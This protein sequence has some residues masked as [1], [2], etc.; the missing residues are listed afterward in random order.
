MI[1]LPDWAQELFNEDYRYIAIKGGRGSA[2]SSSVASALV[3][4]GAKKPLRILCAREVQKSIRDSV[5]R[6]L[7]DKIADHGLGDFYT[8]TD[9]EIRGN[10][11]TLFLFAGLRLN[12][13][14]VKS[15]EGIDICWGEESQAI[16]KVSLEVLVPTIRKPGSQL[17][18][19]W[20]AKQITDPIDA[21]FCS[22]DGPP[23]K[24]CLMKI[25]HDKNPWFP[26]VL[27]DEMEYDKN[28]DYDKYLHIWEGEYLQN[29]E[30]RVFKNW[31]I[32][33]FETPPEAIF[34]FGAD[35]GF[36]SDPTCLIRCFLVGRKLYFD[37]EV[38][39]VGCEIIDTPDLFM[40][41]P[42]AE[43]WPIIA[44][45]ARPET[46]S[47]MRKHG[48]PKIMG[49]IKGPKSLNEGVEFLKTYDII[50]HTR[51]EHLIDELTHY[52][53]KIDELTDTVL[54]ILEDKH[55]HIIDS[56]RYALEGIR[57]AQKKVD[58]VAPIPTVSNWG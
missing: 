49:A 44:D 4:R 17:I 34:R 33:D 10:N 23:P 14:S 8:S 12:I 40:Q 11:G 50:V 46:I 18:F 54:P 22:E 55:N 36:A 57:R 52:K 29:S 28:R 3:L 41:V 39:Q 38:Y 48:F 31:K 56:A 32:E 25:N 35:W 6:L 19:T 2:K 26:E 45:S 1:N 43:R 58:N 42:E 37:Y 27:R 20:N 9:S 7:D 16:S 21:M 24:T 5:K 15:M 51:C 13:D 47:H 30:A 53:Y